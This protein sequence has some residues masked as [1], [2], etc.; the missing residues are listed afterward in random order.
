[1]TSL[2]LILLFILLVFAC[3]G[4]YFGLIHAIGSIAGF[5]LGLAIANKY[6]IVLGAWL[7]SRISFFSIHSL[8][9][10]VFAYI[11]LMFIVS[12]CVGIL[13]YCIERFSKIIRIVPMISTLNRMA[14]A[15]FG[16]IEGMLSIGVALLFVSHFPA[17]SQLT[18]AVAQSSVAQIILKLTQAL[19]PL[20]PQAFRQLQA[21]DWDAYR[22]E[23]A[24]AF[25]DQWHVMES[26]GRQ[27]LLEMI[28]RASQQ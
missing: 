20:L 2:D 3:I 4:F 8:F 13:A 21:I 25:S 10:I 16:L 12:R 18:T 11:F 5:F 28:R 14:G 22:R 7:S 9:S 17:I 15:L 6:Y 27:Q 23:G 24:A 19:L 26:V 1:M